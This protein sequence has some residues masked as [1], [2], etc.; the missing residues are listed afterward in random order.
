MMAGILIWGE[1]Q[2]DLDIY[3][4]IG[5]MLAAIPGILLIL[6]PL[7]GFWEVFVDK[8]DITI[9]KFFVLKKHFLFSEIAYCKEKRGGWKVYVKGRKKPAFFVDRMAEGAGLFLKRIEAVNI[10]VE[11]MIRDK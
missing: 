8:D 5:A 2:D 9:T 7:S 10:P 6:G 4:I 1:L 11:D 3:S